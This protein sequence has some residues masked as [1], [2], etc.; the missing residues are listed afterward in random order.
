MLEASGS[1]GEVSNDPETGLRVVDVIDALMAVIWTRPYI[2]DVVVTDRKRC[3]EGLQSSPQ[4]TFNL[5]SQLRIKLTDSRLGP[6]SQVFR[7]RSLTNWNSPA[8]ARESEVTI[9]CTAF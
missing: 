6:A 3:D 1:T 8:G 5:D 7:F 2:A 9:R 4:M